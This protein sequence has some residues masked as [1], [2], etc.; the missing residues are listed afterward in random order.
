MS[1]K[2]DSKHSSYICSR[3]MKYY[4]KDTFS[5]SWVL[6]ITQ[7]LITRCWNKAVFIPLFPNQGIETHRNSENRLEGKDLNFPQPPLWTLGIEV[8]RQ[9][10]KGG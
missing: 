6:I 2:C 5:F 1:T 9:S 8:R 3:I 7:G 4:N 10:G